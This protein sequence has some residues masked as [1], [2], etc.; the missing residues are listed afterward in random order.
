MPVR[1]GRDGTAGPAKFLN[2]E[3]LCDE[4]GFNER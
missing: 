3:R 2:V 4:V 1:D